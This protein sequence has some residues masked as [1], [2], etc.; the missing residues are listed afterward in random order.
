MIPTLPIPP[1]LRSAD[2]RSNFPR[3]Q[4]KLW[5]RKLRLQ[6]QFFTAPSSG[7]MVRNTVLETICAPSAVGWIP[8]RWK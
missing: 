1:D 5:N 6:V 3:Q 7:L 8:S 4:S 2:H